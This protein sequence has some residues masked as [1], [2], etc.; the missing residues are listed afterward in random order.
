MECQMLDVMTVGASYSKFAKLKVLTEWT[1][2]GVID[3]VL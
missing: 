1:N 2:K 3:Q